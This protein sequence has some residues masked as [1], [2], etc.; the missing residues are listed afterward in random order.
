M[1]DVEAE[2][3]ANSEYLERVSSNLYNFLVH[4]MSGETYMV[5]RGPY[6]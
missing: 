4:P 5:V 1:R 6:D 3:E 2:T